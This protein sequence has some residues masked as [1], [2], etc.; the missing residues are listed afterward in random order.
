MIQSALVEQGISTGAFFSPYVVEPRERIQVGREF[1]SEAQLAEITRF[2]KPIGESLS[3]TDFGGVTEFEF[4]TALGLECWKRNGCEFVALEVGLGG[5]LDATNIIN[6]AC[7]AIVS[8]GLDHV[9]ILGNTVEEIAFEKAGVLKPGRPD[10]IGEM[11]PGPLRVIEKQAAE[12]G[13]DIWRVGIEVK[14][15]VNSNG[16]VTVQTPTSQIDLEPSLFGAVQQHNAAVAYASI[17]L[18]GALRD[19][20]S[21]QRGFAT[22]AIP[23]R[24][25]R[26]EHRGVEWVFDGAHNPDSAK[27]LAAMLSQDGKQDLICVTG[28]LQ[29]HDPEKFYPKIAPFVREFWV[30]PVDNPRSMTP[31]ELAQTIR[32]LGL[33]ARIFDRTVAAI[34]AA[35]HAKDTEGYLVSGS[36]YA[37]GEIVRL[38]RSAR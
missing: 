13:A 37:V 17:E 28:M 33:K 6:P 24:Y 7:S 9:S 20:E 29:G 10:V 5:R 38:L 16:M 4:K 3:E 22:A 35:D 1:I 25:Q 23:G 18:G 31:E 21:I 8:I 34:E 27:V 19:K 11:A 32:Q 12:V 26:L 14:Y 15:S 30:V 36:F 2:L